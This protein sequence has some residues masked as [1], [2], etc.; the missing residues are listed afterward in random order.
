[1]STKDELPPP[2]PTIDE[3]ES[4]TEL[5][6]YDTALDPSP[7]DPSPLEPLPEEPLPEEP[8]PEPSLMEPP[9]LGAWL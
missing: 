4:T 3:D 1:M 8:A 6:A 5:G 2:L 7:L 9:P